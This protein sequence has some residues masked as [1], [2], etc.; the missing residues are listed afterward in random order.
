MGGVLH[1]MPGLR[2][3]KS[4]GG[5][6]KHQQKTKMKIELDQEKVSEAINIHINKAVEDA[7]KGHSVREAI[8]QKISAQL[9]D[10]AVAKAI[11]NAVSRV[12]TGKL[13]QAIAEQIQKTMVSAVA[14]IVQESFL[15]IMANMRGFASYEGEEK[16]RYI[17]ELKAKFAR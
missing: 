7:L 17:E 16:T 10:G 2:G 8:A 6:S 13:T 3:I 11:D 1:I 4:G 12:D 15:G 14:H 9:A 5:E